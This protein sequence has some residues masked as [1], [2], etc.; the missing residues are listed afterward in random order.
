MYT[1][2]FKLRKLPFRLRPDPEFLFLGAEAG[3]LLDALR[4]AVDSGHGLLSLTGEAGV[5][6][7]T[8]LHAIARERQGSMAVARIQQPNLTAEELVATLA[9]QFGL[10]PLDAG[11]DGAARLTQFVA[12]ERGHG[13]AVL[14]C[15]STVT[16]TIATLSKQIMGQTP[17]S[18]P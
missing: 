10:P 5:G 9:E 4:A 15:Y 18:P 1:D 8:L 17:S 12:E 7:T 3:P 13:R 16:Q 6:K 2:W 14:I 11:G